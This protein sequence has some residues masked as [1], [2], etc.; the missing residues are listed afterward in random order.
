MEREAEMSKVSQRIRKRL[1]EI[2]NKVQVRMSIDVKATE[3]AGVEEVPRATPQELP[4]ATPF[5]LWFD[6]LERRRAANVRVQR[7]RERA[8][9]RFGP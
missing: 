3:V 9:R 8:A 7:R 6:I 5:E 2:D 4:V 1:R